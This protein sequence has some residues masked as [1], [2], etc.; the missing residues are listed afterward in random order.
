VG[1]FLARAGRLEARDRRVAVWCAVLP[2][3]DAVTRF[4]G[5]EAYLCGHHV[6]GHNLLAA[7]VLAGGALLLARRK[8]TV[9]LVS[10]AAVLLHFLSD[11]L[12]YLEIRP[13]WPFSRWIFWPGQGSHLVAMIGEVGIPLPLVWWSA[14]VFRREGVS[15]L[16]AVSPRLDGALGRRLRR[17]A[18]EPVRAAG[19]EPRRTGRPLLLL[20]VREL[21]FGLALYGAVALLCRTLLAALDAGSWG[22]ALL[23]A[24]PLFA[25][26]RWPVPWAAR[27][28]LRRYARSLPREGGA[29]DSRPGP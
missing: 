23:L 19:A 27:L 9:F 5:L 4:G 1:W 2:D 6:Y 18:E 10:L 29:A 26:A 25:A 11:G 14:A 17:Y 24:L 12:G 16:E 3:L 15:V 13:L 8:L 28:V 22:S 20:A 7:L 21:L